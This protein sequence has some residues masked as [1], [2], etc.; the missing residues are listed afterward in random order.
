MFYSAVKLVW[1][2]GVVLQAA[3]VCWAGAPEAARRHRVLQ[4]IRRVPE[5]KGQT[6]LHVRLPAPH[7]ERQEEVGLP[8][9]L[10]TSHNYAITRVKYNI[11]QEV[12][13]ICSSLPGGW[14]LMCLQA[15]LRAAKTTENSPTE[16]TMFMLLYK[17]IM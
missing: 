14:R 2:V 5:V 16:K 6:Q 11:K 10:C 13:V 9:M 4:Q 15:K 8:S 7:A 12:G 1:D 3:A 17:S